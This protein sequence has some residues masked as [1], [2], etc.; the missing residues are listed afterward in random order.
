M[1]DLAHILLF[2]FS[3]P[4]NDRFANSFL[5]TVAWLV[6]GCYPV[7][8]AIRY[9][10]SVDVSVMRGV[11]SGAARLTRVD[12]F[13]DGAW[14]RVAG[15]ALA[16]RAATG[17]LLA[18]TTSPAFAV[19]NGFGISSVAVRSSTHSPSTTNRYS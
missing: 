4:A 14:R 17:D 1:Y 7:A 5:A 8:A 18:A 11:G 19:P 6:R 12:D 16:G 10:V 13:G 3:V 2:Y 9:A 15:E